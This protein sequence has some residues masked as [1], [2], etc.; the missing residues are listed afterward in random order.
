MERNKR[1]TKETSNAEQLSLPFSDYPVH[2]QQAD[3]L[4]KDAQFY[5]DVYLVKGTK[6]YAGYLRQGDLTLAI[7]NDKNL[8]FVDFVEETI[9]LVSCKFG[10]LAR[11]RCIRNEGV[12]NET[13]KQY[14]NINFI[15][16]GIKD[17]RN[18]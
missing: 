6:G 18:E 8:K 10:L 15:K 13:D 11:F 2:E 14:D 7:I 16:K 3:R 12:S 5:T 17:G 4:K 9:K 1:E